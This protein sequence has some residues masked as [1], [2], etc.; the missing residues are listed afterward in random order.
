MASFY[1]DIYDI[2]PEEALGPSGNMYISTNQI[3][4]FLPLVQY[5]S[6]MTSMPMYS[7]I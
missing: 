7:P 3:M 1:T 2:K 5:V 6:I 4:G